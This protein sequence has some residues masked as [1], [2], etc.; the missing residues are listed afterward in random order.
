MARSGIYEQLSMIWCDNLTISHLYIDTIPGFWT[1]SQPFDSEIM[2]TI[3][4]Q[5][6]WLV[7]KRPSPMQLAACLSVSGTQCGGMRLV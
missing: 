7:A 5:V 4:T 2:S 3:S 6:K 1:S